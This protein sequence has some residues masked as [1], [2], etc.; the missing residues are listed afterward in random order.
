MTTGKHAMAALA[1]LRYAVNAAP[2][3][4]ASNELADLMLAAD[5]MEGLQAAGSY[6]LAVEAMEEQAKAASTRIRAALAVVMAESGAS[7]VD[8]AHHTMA[9]VE[10]KPRP[11]ISDP[12]MLPP[13][14]LVPQPPK[15]DMAAITR[16]MKAGPVPGVSLSNSAPHVRIAAKGTKP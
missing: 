5:L 7:G 9:L 8:L 10:P 16:A 14:Y 15:P 12:A 11:F 3:E 4:L 2:P 13:E 1:T 6:L